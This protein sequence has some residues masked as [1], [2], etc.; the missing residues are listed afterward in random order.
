MR[1]I[2]FFLVAILLVACND[3]YKSIVEAAP[4]PSIRF[5]SD[6]LYIREKD[7]T[8][9]NQSNKGMVQIYCMPSSHQF[10][11]SFSDTSGKLHFMYRGQMLP[12]SQP[13]VVTG[14]DNTLYCYADVP[15][16]YAVDFLLSDQ[17]GKTT[18][19]KM[20]VRCSPSEKPIASLK[21]EE[22][23]GAVSS[24]WLYYFDGSE[25]RQ[26]FGAIMSYHYLINGVAYVTTQ[27]LF[28]FSF[29][30]AGQQEVDFFVVDDLGNASDTLHYSILTK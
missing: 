9:I 6:T 12:D 5:A 3:K 20:I 1:T 29:H 27:R 26:P 7:P 16:T 19:K 15:G 23:P 14:E 28:K 11:L 22:R 25:S 10:S 18:A 24:G 13:F 30:E 17:L 4:D 2:Y 8:N 21:Y